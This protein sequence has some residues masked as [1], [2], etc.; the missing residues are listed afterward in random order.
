MKEPTPR[1]SARAV[2]AVPSGA[3]GGYAEY[4]VAPASMTFP[5]PEGIPLPDAAAI[6]MPFHLAALSLYVRGRP[7]G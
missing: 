7:S 3:F 2:V 1:S 6:L 4:A 5:M